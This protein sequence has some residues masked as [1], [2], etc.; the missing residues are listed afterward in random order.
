MDN[1]TA[2]IYSKTYEEHHD[3]LQEVFTWIQNTGFTLNLEKVRL[4][5]SEIKLLGT[6]C[7]P[8]A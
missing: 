7:Q 2:S 8:K 4:V 6:P 1:L 5:Q 3:H